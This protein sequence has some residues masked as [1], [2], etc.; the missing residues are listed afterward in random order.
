M[1]R[2]PSAD[3][4]RGR[5]GVNWRDWRDEDKS[6]AA[7]QQAPS[8]DRVLASVVRSKGFVWLAEDP[9]SA[10]VWAHAGTHVE[11]TRHGPWETTRESSGSKGSRKQGLV[12]IGVGL[13]G[14]AASVLEAELTSCLSIE[15]AP[16]PQ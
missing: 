12:F 1:R 2:L 13:A 16:P 5:V 3:N 10:Y 8:I 14:E 6:R 4:W 9:G 11:L 15:G 7:Q